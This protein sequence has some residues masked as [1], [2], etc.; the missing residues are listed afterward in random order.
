MS[1]VAP[2]KDI[3]FVMQELAGLEAIGKMP[4]SKRRPATRS[5]PFSRR[6]RAFAARCWR[7]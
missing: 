6:T 4:G 7:R 2:V 5:T 3:R 1:Y